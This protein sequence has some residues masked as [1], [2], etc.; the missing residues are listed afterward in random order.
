[1]ATELDKL[2]VRIEADL[3]DLKKGLKQAG[4]VTKRNSTKMRKNLQTLNNSFDNLG[5]AV[6]KYGAIIGTAFAGFQIKKI[7]DTGSEIEN[8]TVRLNA[9]FGSA[10][11]GAKAFRVMLDFAGRVPFELKEIQ[12]ASGNLAVVTDNANELAEILEITGNVASITGL[13]FSQTAEQIQ[14]SFSG[15]IASADVFR[16]KGVRNMLNFS[17][18]V[19][20]SLAETKQA[21]RDTFGKGGVYGNA[22][23]EFAKT[24]SGTLSMLQDKLL[25]FRIAIA[26]EFFPE[27]KRTLQDLNHELQDNQ[28]AIEKYGNEIGRDLA[29]TTKDFIENIDKILK[30]LKAFSLFLA[31]TATIAIGNYLHKLG[32]LKGGFLGLG[33]ATLTFSDE[34]EK[35][36]ENYLEHRGN[37]HPVIGLLKE[38][39]EQN[40]K[41]T[42][43]LEEHNRKIKE[44]IDTYKAS[45][46]IQG[47]YGKFNKQVL[48]KEVENTGM[49]FET[50]QEI[51]EGINK[52]FEDAGESI[53]QAFGDSI[54]KGEDFK[55][56]M[57]SI[58]QDVISQIIATIVHIRIIKPMIDSLTASLNEQV[59][60]QKE[61]NDA[62]GGSGFSLGN[63]IGSTIGSM[64]GFAKG[65]FTGGSNPIM[66]GEKGAEVFVPRTAGNIIPNNQL[67]GGGSI[68]IN[69]S[70]NFATGVVP[71]VR[72]EVMNLMP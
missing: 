53:S 12:Q 46:I 15:G 16:E 71:T 10:D 52:T 1:M 17:A 64:M 26:Q 41:T 30:G 6:L 8:L 65:G 22:T 3:Q 44:M 23:N 29:E 5:K 56:A 49:T 50:L 39:E 13:S 27:V 68:V 48:Q 60:A 38:N 57:K 28:D 2:V 67:G 25:I 21:F 66:V 58:F 40:N 24:L 32:M 61:A 47:I 72:A 45:I 55:D 9:L 7:I 34:L 33:I 54:A 59:K 43:S 36:G 31:G 14:R 62:G 18:G 69:Q 51:V 4:D 35:L 70:L 20:V 37:I 19:Q 11:E 63:V 42:N